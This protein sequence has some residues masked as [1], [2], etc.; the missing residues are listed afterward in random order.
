MNVL[1]IPEDFNPTDKDKYEETL[2]SLCFY[3][4][5]YGI[6]AVIVDLEA[7]EQQLPKI[8]TET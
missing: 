8:N 4:D 3:V 6:D 5:H 2:K 1:Y 7:I